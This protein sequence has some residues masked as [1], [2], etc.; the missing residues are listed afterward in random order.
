MAY[1]GAVT[2]GGEADVRE[3]TNLTI[4][5]VAVGPMT[6]NVYVLHCRHT[7]DQVLIDAAFDD[8]AILGLVGDAGLATIVTTHRHAD[9]VQ[10][11]EDVAA[12]TGAQT[13][14][15]T[16]DAD[17]LPLAPDVRVGDGDTVA[18][19]TCSMSVIHLAGHTPGSIALRYDDPDGHPHLFTGDSLFPGGPGKTTSDADFDSLMRDLQAKVFDVM[20]DDTWVYPGHGDD[21]TLGAE[22]G[23]IPEWLARRW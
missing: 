3:L 20:P 8:D 18:V 14:A 5:K 2:V 23:S 9:H 4:S 7:G 10:A 19:G 1:T 11:L 15:G 16:D 6:N 22:R 13:V 12:A 17:A 21:T